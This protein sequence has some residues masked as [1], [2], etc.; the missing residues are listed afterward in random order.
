MFGKV[1]KTY[2]GEKNSLFNKYYLDKWLSA[3]STLTLDP[4]LSLC[5]YINSKFTKDSDIRLQTL[6]L[7]Q[8]RAVGVGKDF[9]SR[10]QVTQ[11]LRKD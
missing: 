3:Y 10:T 7:V 5:T 8:E 2:D 9:L 4:C 6:N 1:P 11:E